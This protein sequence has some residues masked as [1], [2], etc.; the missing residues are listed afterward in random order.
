MKRYAICTVIGDGLTPETA[1]RP[2]IQD[3]TDPQTGNAAY[4]IASVI[5]TAPNG[6]PALPWCLCVIAGRR[7]D[8][9]QAHAD[10]D[11]LPDVPLDI[12]VQAIQ[13]GT[14]AAMKARMQARGIDTATVDN[15]DGFR[16]VVRALGQLHAPDFNENAFDVSE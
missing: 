8:L 15:A 3:I 13:A 11:L 10:I 6:Q 12:K 1:F 14:K 5:A 4:S 2:A 16:D 9:A 7:M